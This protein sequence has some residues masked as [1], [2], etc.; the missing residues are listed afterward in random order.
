MRDG[1]QW[2]I[3]ITNS[4]FGMHQT[5]SIAHDY[6]RKWCT[7]V[8]SIAP[9]GTAKAQ[10]DEMN[11]TQGYKMGMARIHYQQDYG[12][13]KAVEGAVNGWNNRNNVTSK[14]LLL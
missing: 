10:Q 3:D 2:F 11:G 14:C 4:Q 9:L 12:T 6:T 8:R 13:V 1:R 7:R 5:V